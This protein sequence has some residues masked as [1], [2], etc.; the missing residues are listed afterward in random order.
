MK[1]KGKARMT[2]MLKSGKALE[3]FSVKESDL[4]NFVQ[5]AKQYG[6]LISMSDKGQLKLKLQSRDT[7]LYRM[8]DIVLKLRS[9]DIAMLKLEATLQMQDDN[10]EDAKSNFIEAM[11]GTVQDIWG[12]ESE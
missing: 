7:A 3:I 9:M 11:M 2:S 8:A 12:D 4:K 6:K 10:P 5:G 1:P